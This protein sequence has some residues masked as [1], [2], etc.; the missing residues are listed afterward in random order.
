MNFLNTPLRRLGGI[1]YWVI[2]DPEAIHDYV[3]TEIRKEWETDARS[4]HRN[5]KDDP[6]L[7]TL[8]K[9]KWSLRVTETARIKLNPYFM[10]YVDPQ[11]GYDF[12]KRIAERGQELQQCIKLGAQ[13]IWPLVVRK[14]DLQLMD[15]YCRFTALTA[16]NVSRTYVYIGVL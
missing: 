14:E 10:N 11:T 4:E 8:P 16:M 9:R 6:W 12:R 1:S 15:G 13:V 5:P 3:N 2:E 7:Q